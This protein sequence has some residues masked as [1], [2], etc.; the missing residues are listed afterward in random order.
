MFG[1]EPQCLNLLSAPAMINWL[2]KIFFFSF[3]Y[4]EVLEGSASVKLGIF[5]SSKSENPIVITQV[6][7]NQILARGK[8][9]IPVSVA[10]LVSL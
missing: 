4:G 9:R 1:G 3:V 6:E 5:N 7:S 10:D 8:L 2:F